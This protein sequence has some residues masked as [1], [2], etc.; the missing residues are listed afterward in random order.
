[1]TNTENFQPTTQTVLI[2]GNDEKGFRV[3]DTTNLPSPLPMDAD[4]VFQVVTVEV[5]TG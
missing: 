3:L 4:D 2:I 5:Y 1:M